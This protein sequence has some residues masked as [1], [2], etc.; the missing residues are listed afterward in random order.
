M[1]SRLPAH[2]NFPPITFLCSPR[3]WAEHVKERTL[4][5]RQNYQYKVH[6]AKLGITA[7]TIPGDAAAKVKNYLFSIFERYPDALFQEE[8]ITNLDDKVG[9]T[10]KPATT[11]VVMRSSTS[12]FETLPLSRISKQNLANDLAAMGLLL[13]RKNKDRHPSIQDFMLANDSWTIACE[14]PVYLTSEEVAYYRSKGFFLPLPELPKPITG[15]IDIVQIRNGLIHLL[16]YKPKARQIDAVNQL[17]IYALAFA[18]RARLPVKSFKCAWFDGK[19]FFEF[20]PLQAIKAKSAA[21][22]A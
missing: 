6:L 10:E 3:L 20:F 5:H 1:D 15:H 8:P 18:S 4:E 17:V 22:P 19:D 12:D 16:D 9:T 13:A 21:A 14:V 7:R 11:P 2:H